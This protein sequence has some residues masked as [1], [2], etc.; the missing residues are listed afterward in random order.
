MLKVLVTGGAG[1]IGSHTVDVLVENGFNVLAI[2]NLCTG[3][4]KNINPKASFV[5]LDVNNKEVEQI[6]SK[7]QP[8][9]LIHLAAQVKV[10]QSISDPYK[11]AMDNI[12]GTIRLL[13]YCDKYSVKK[14]IFASSAA[15]YGENNQLPLNESSIISPVS[16]YGVSKFTCEAYI[17]LFNHYKNIQYTILR[18]SNVYGPRQT[19]DAEGGVV[20]TFLNHIIENKPLVIYGD[21]EQTRDFIYV[22][23]LA[24]A[25]MA[26]ITKGN[27]EIINISTESSTSINQL[28][29]MCKDI[30]KSNIIPKYESARAGD[31]PHSLLENRKA[32]DLLSWKPSY[33]LVEGLTETVHSLNKIK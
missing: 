16:F 31:I 10:S 6:F 8:D 29:S 26:A 4:K 19:A 2:D 33:T 15:V 7:F 30:L 20:S 5:N 9:I 17:R 25:N 28:F 32:R 14:V 1:F 11:D 22:K 21:G 3:K 18:Y 12:M 13:S 24:K 23:D 27:N